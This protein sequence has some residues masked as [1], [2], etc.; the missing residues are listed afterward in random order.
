M[1]FSLILALASASLTY[2]LV[3]LTAKLS[4]LTDAIDKPDGKR[5]INTESLPRLGGLSFLPQ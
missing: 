3:P 1:L 2:L 4:Y 5:K